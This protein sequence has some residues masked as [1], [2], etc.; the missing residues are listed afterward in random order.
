MGYLDVVAAE[1]EP[2]A[3]HYLPLSPV[4][5]QLLLSLQPGEVEGGAAAGMGR[6]A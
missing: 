5:L 3:L 4:L 2:A 1:H 6:P